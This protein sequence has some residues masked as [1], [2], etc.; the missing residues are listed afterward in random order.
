MARNQFKKRLA[1]YISKP[2][3][4]PKL[5][6]SSHKYL[7]KINM[8]MNPSAIVNQDK[9]KIAAYIDSDQSNYFM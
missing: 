4:D 6:L 8:I 1:K 7:D 9:V 3:S 5:G 2:K